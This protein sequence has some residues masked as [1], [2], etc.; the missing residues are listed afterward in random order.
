[1]GPGFLLGIN[2]DERDGIGMDKTF[3]TTNHQMRQL[4]SRGLR[5]EGSYAKRILEKENYYNLINGYKPSFID[6]SYEGPDERYK[7]GTEFKEIYALF[8]F[9]RELRSVFLRYILEIEN[10]LRSVIAHDFAMKYGHDNYLIINNFN[11][12]NESMGDIIDLISTLQRDVANQI[13]R[14]LM[15]LYLR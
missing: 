2:T 5:I 15:H 11:K 3:M 12:T 6:K 9:D 13:K 1:M 8:L 7:A 10:N 4:R 14:P